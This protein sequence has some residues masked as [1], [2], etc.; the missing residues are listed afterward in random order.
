[1]VEGPQI[2]QPS[3]PAM[4]SRLM[5]PTPV[6]PPPPSMKTDA[7]TTPRPQP[8]L[9]FFADFSAVIAVIIDANLVG[10][11]LHDPAGAV[12]PCHTLD[13]AAH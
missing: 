7:L 4:F 13:R 5:P 6:A 3:A 2:M 8:Q 11:R 1:M 9:R 12:F 10:T